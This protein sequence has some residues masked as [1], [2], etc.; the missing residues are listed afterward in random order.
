MNLTLTRLKFTPKTT[1]GE[2]MV[3]D[4]WQCWTLED[5]V[6]SGPKVPGETAIPYGSYEIV[7][8]YSQRFRR[9]M[10]LLLDVPGFEGIRI[11]SGNTASDTHGCI[12]VGR[13]RVDDDTIGESRLAFAALFPRLQSASQTEKIWIEVRRQDK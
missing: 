9:V 5:A 2:L 1:I 6:R 12:L 13:T 10:P 3:E 7:L 11:H 4:K 8:T